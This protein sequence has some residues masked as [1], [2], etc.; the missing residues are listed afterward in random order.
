[1]IFFF[2]LVISFLLLFILDTVKKGNNINKNIRF[3]FF[4]FLVIMIQSMRAILLLLLL[5]TSVYPY[6]S[7]T[8]ILFN[9]KPLSLIPFFLQLL[10]VIQMAAVKNQ[11]LPLQLLTLQKPW[12]LP[13]LVHLLLQSFMRPLQFKRRRPAR[14]IRVPEQRTGRS[15]SPV[16]AVSLASQVLLRPS[17]S[18]VISERALRISNSLQTKRKVQKRNFL[19]TETNQRERG[20]RNRVN[21]V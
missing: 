13:P 18:S 15:L 6:K 20:S 9:Q 5:C 19:Q 3:F 21:P 17:L 16:S 10:I 2:P 11:S 14:H 4:F 12:L 8:H 7:K 1:M